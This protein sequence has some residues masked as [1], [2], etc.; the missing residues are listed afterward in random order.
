RLR[1]RRGFVAASRDDALRATLLAHAN[2]PKPATPPE[3]A[4]HVSPLIR[5]WFGVSRGTR[6]TSRVTFVWEPA[7]RVPGDRGVRSS[8]ARLVLTARAADGAVLFDGPVA[9]TGP[10]VV[11]EPGA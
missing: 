3:P 4:P 6:G 9:A 10:G 2:D 5:P 8:P 7:S 1:A 11:N